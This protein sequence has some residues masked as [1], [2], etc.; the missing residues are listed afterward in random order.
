MVRYILVRAVAFCGLTSLS[1]MVLALPYI[2]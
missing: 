1:T 2:A